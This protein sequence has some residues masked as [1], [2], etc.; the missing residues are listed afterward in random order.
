[1]NADTNI[2]RKLISFKFCAFSPVSL[3]K[4]EIM[5]SSHHHWDHRH[6]QMNRRIKWAR[7]Q[8]KGSAD[9]FHDTVD[10]FPRISWWDETK[11]KLFSPRNALLII[12][13]IV[14]ETRMFIDCFSGLMFCGVF[15]TLVER[16]WTR[17]ER[18]VC[19]C[20][21]TNWR[22]INAFWWRL[23]RPRIISPPSSL[24]MWTAFP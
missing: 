11:T 17:R 21:G 7:Q 3:L 2:M 24:S 19:V 12:I 23:L 5:Q 6:N 8:A 16:H 20:V 9:L 15:T 13:Y 14:S 18:H 4:R 1:M 22:L 10:S